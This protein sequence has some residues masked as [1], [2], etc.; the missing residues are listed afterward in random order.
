[1]NEVLLFFQGQQSFALTHKG[2]FASFSELDSHTIPNLSPLNNAL[3][4]LDRY[5]DT[6]LLWLHAVV[7][8]ACKPRLSQLLF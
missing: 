1:M 8:N 2:S 4:E 3:P 7:Q 6:L 5:V